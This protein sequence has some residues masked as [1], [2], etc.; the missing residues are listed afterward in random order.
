[1]GSALAAMNAA[2]QDRPVTVAPLSALPLVKCDGILIERVLC[3]LLEN[4]AKYTPPGSAIHIDALADRQRIFE[5]FARGQRE[6]APRRRP[7]AGGM[8]RHPGRPPGPHLG[9]AGPAPARRLLRLR[10]AA[11]PAAGRA[12]E[13]A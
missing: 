4:A 9:R 7:R 2:L 8:P 11:D 3:N 1:M 6:S 10:A 13:P 12:P 5:K